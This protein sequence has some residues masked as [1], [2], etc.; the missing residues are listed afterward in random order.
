ML[1]HCICINNKILLWEEEYMQ[2]MCE[3]LWNRTKTLRDILNIQ[4]RKHTVKHLCKGI[5]HKFWSS[6]LYLKF[7]ELHPTVVWQEGILVTEGENDF[8]RWLSHVNRDFRLVFSALSTLLLGNCHSEL[9]PS[10]TR[11]IELLEKKKAET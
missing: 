10:L 2:L 5:V 3:E 7:I 9:F 4:E 11:K 8:L 6:F 1:H